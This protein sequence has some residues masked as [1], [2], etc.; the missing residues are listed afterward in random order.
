VCTAVAG[1]GVP[2]LPLLQVSGAADQAHALQ[3]GQGQSQAGNLAT[4]FLKSLINSKNPD[5]DPCPGY[6]VTG[7]GSGSKTLIFCDFSL[8]TLFGRKEVLKI[9]FNV[10]LLLFEFLIT[11]V[12]FRTE[13]HTSYFYVW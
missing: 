7:S 2:V 12:I 4:N 5:L 11:Y 9:S 1:P 8:G 10:I 3:G 6:G 13:G